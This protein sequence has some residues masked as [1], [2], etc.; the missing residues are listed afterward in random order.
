VLKPDIKALLRHIFYI[1]KVLYHKRNSRANE[2]NYFT[3]FS[4]IYVF[5]FKNL[6]KRDS[7][8]N[9]Y[10]NK[11]DSQNYGEV[12]S[13]CQNNSIEFCKNVANWF[14]TR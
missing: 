13:L 7:A 11:V 9:W 14:A 12:N 4:L 8:V 1:F 5:N 3:S 6:V 10:L 2:C